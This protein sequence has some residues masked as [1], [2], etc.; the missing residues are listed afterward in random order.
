[1]GDRR[2]ASPLDRPGLGRALAVGSVVIVLLVLASLVFVLARSA[3]V[4]AGAIWTI[5]LMILVTFATVGG[6]GWGLWRAAGND[7]E[8]PPPGEEGDTEG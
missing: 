3:G 8:A 2:P 5:L 4:E 6:I 7:G 1:M